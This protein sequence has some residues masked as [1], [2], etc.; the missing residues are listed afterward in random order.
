M[1]HSQ[2]ASNTWVFWTTNMYSSYSL[3]R[4]ALV[5][6]QSQ[7]TL[8]FTTFHTKP[9]TLNPTN[10]QVN[11]WRVTIKFDRELK[12]TKQNWKLQLYRYVSHISSMI[13][14]GDYII[15]WCNLIHTISHIKNSVDSEMC[16]CRH[17]SLYQLI[18]LSLSAQ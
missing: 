15:I 1:S 11:D 16:S 10:I 9:I 17:P 8:F 7:N 12:P 4:V 13:M 2:N 5:M 6:S 14:M 18:I 3:S